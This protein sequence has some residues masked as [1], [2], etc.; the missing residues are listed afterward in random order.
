MYGCWRRARSADLRSSPANGMW[1]RSRD[2]VGLPTRRTREHYHYLLKTAAIHSRPGRAAD[3]QTAAVY[4]RRA[5]LIPAREIRRG[6]GRALPARRRADRQASIRCRW[7]SQDAPMAHRLPRLSAHGMTCAAKRL[8]SRSAA[9]GRCRDLNEQ[10]LRD[11]H[12]RKHHRV[13]DVGP[14]RGDGAVRVDQNGGIP[15]DAGD[16]AEQIVGR[17]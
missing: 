4:S 8:G 3:L 13:A 16:D 5:I 2:V 11:G 10:D 1:P 9:E 17:D 12:R 6:R 14:L 15:R 7:A